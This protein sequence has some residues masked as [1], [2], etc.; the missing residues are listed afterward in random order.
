VE[1]II[2]RIAMNIVVGGCLG[3]AVV[4]NALGIRTFVRRRRFTTLRMGWIERIVTPEPLI[5]GVVTL[6]I[7]R[8]EVDWDDPS[9][10]E[11]V[12]ASV[13]AVLVAAA[14]AL[15]GWAF[16]T[17]HGHFFGHGILPDQR[18]VTNGAYG[19][20]RHPAYTCAI[21]VWIGL[22]IG[23]LDPVA[24]VLAVAYVIPAYAGY[25]WSEERMLAEAFG[26]EYLRYREAVPMLAPWPRASRAIGE[27][28][29]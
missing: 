5:L 1:Q 14:V 13:A 4:A 11:V 16:W 18:L 17:W 22:A 6:W 3:R 21:L 15:V 26:E 8:V 25:I 10:A 19:F 12:A 7:M 27:A 23:A 24:S 9:H 29:T 20:V 28:R 2:F